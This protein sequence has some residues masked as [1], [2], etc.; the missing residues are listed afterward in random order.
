MQQLQVTNKLTINKFNIIQPKQRKTLQISAKEATQIEGLKE[1]FINNP[2]LTFVAQI[3][4]MFMM[5]KGSSDLVLTVSQSPVLVACMAEEGN[6]MTSR[7]QASSS[8]QRWKGATSYNWEGEGKST[9]REGWM[10]DVA[11]KHRRRHDGERMGAE[12]EEEEEQPWAVW[13]MGFL[14]SKSEGE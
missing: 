9:D 11:Q 6:A 14:S 3:L 7:Q 10:N 1:H 12:K 4:L 2:K 13:D 8:W 5:K